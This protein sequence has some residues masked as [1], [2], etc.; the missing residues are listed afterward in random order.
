SIPTRRVMSQQRSAWDGIAPN[1]KTTFSVP[2]ATR[3][4][5]S[6]IELPVLLVRGARP[7]RTLLA[8]AGGH[9]DEV[10]GMGALRR[11]YESLQ[12]EQLSGTLVAV[13]VAN[14]PAYEAALRTNPDDRQ[15]L[16]RTFPG[17][18]VGTVTEQIAF[19]LTHRFIRHADLYC[20]LHSAGQY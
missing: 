13:P 7:G 4:D 19:A 3:A 20:D 10:E 2:V 18:A 9:G 15:D 14:P 1:S 16:A 6:R 11:L 17:N 5:G 8:T 12:P